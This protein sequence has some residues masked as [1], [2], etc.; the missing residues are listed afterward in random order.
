[1]KRARTDAELN[2]VVEKTWK[3]FPLEKLPSDVV[4]TLIFRTGLSVFDMMRLC[5]IN[6]RFRAIC[7]KREIW[8]KVFIERFVANKTLSEEEFGQYRLAPEFAEWVEESKRMPR[9]FAHLIARSLK[10][11]M[12]PALSQGSL[13]AHLAFNEDTLEHEFFIM[14]WDDLDEYSSEPNI[15]HSSEYPTSLK[16][17]LEAVDAEGVGNYKMVQSQKYVELIYRMLMDGWHPALGQPLINL[18]C[19]LCG[20]DASNSTGLVCSQCNQFAFCSTSCMDEYL[21]SDSTAAAEHDAYCIKHNHKEPAYLAERLELLIKDDAFERTE[22]EL[23]RME[24]LHAEL[25]VGDKAAAEEAYA[26]VSALSK[27]KTR[28]KAKKKRGGKGRSGSSTRRSAARQNK[29]REASKKR[30]MRKA[31][32]SQ[33]RSK[34]KEKKN[35]RAAQRS[36]SK[37]KRAASKENKKRDASKKRTMRKAARSQSRSKSAE[38]KNQ[39]AAQRSGRSKSKEPRSRSRSKSA[40]KKN[41]PAE[42]KGSRSRSKSKGKDKSRGRSRERSGSILSTR[43]NKTD[44][45]SYKGPTFNFGGRGGAPSLP[46]APSMPSVPQAPSFGGGGSSAPPASAPQTTVVVVP[47]TVPPPTPAP[48]QKE[49]DKE[50]DSGDTESDDEGPSE[51]KISL[52]QTSAGLRAYW[53]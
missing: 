42:S 7:Q 6:Q 32:R 49:K 13:E 37:S 21:E 30:T 53:N 36:G 16:T 35:Q 45:R 3:D 2:A 23:A 10:E 24:Q 14:N 22:D 39:R 4:Y 48:A 20:A 43:S 8:D 50:A 19:E 41:Q 15:M 9:A 47:Q 28:T 17:I 31:A 34:S 40:E 52:V 44:N 12:D 46:Q 11:L 51:I 29:K 38:K 26:M 5:S 33:S 25:V 18:E 1:M 27:T